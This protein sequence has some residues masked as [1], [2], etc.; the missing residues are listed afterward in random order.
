MPLTLPESGVCTYPTLNTS[1][2][3]PADGED[4][5]PLFGGELRQ[6]NAL[7]RPLPDLPQVADMNF[8]QLADAN[9]KCF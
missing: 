7:E 9:R 5:S 3:Y 4:Y 1:R 8:I 6:I 2:L